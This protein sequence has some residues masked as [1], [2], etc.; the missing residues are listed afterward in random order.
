VSTY[1]LLGLAEDF[2]IRPPGEQQPGYRMDL[3][4][5]IGVVEACWNVEAAVGIHNLDLS[6]INLRA[7]R[8]RP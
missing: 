2:C 7:I 8:D 1:P 5:R 3:S 6:Q 4:V